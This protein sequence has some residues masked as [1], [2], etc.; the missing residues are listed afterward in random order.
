VDF[1]EQAH[2]R[3]RSR[4]AS[5][6]DKFLGQLSQETSRLNIRVSFGKFDQN[7]LAISIQILFHF[8]QNESPYLLFF[9]LY[10]ILFLLEEDE[11]EEEA[12]AWESLSMWLIT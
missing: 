3:I 10:F 4:Q 12:G 11:D 8:L 6:T 7:L 2:I 9:F 5:I 1:L